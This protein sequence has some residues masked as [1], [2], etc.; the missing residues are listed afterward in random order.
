MLNYKPMTASGYFKSF[1]INIV[2]GCFGVWNYWG[3]NNA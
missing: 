1:N 3:D 2:I